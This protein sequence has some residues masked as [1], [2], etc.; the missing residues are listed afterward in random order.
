M[1]SAVPMNLECRLSL[2]DSPNSVGVAID[3]IRCAKIARKCGL[4]GPGLGP[5]AY[6][7]KQPLVQS[8]DDE[9]HAATEAFIRGD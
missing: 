4:G 7:C 3:I 5:S 9:A 8:T 1:F 2:E 6:F